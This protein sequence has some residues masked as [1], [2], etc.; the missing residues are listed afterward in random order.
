M[1]GAPLNMTDNNNL[2]MNPSFNNITINNIFTPSNQINLGFNSQGPAFFNLGLNII[3]NSDIYPIQNNQN[4]DF[5]FQNQQN[6][7]NNNFAM[8]QEEDLKK[9]RG[10]YNKNHIINKKVIYY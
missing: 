3:T 2:Q 7:Y 9:K 1:M 4:N 10:N 8:K 6:N 5:S